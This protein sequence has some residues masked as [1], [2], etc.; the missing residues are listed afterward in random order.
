MPGEEITITVMPPGHYVLDGLNTRFDEYWS[1]P[2]VRRFNHIDG[3]A[4][5]NGTVAVVNNSIALSNEE[6]AVDAIQELCRQCEDAA[7]WVGAKAPI[8]IDCRAGAEKKYRLFDLNMKP[9]LTG[10]SRPH[11]QDQ[12]CL[13][14]IASEAMGW[15]FS[16]LI[17]NMLMQCWKL[18]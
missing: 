4:P 10:P 18:A 2:A 15:D 5:Y 13:S 9:N 6:L 3:V 12:T 17:L 14:A 11:R 7:K 8:R 1:L 16:D